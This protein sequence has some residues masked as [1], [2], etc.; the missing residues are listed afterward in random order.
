MADISR[1]VK[2]RTRSDASSRLRSDGEMTTGQLV[3]RALALKH[4]G[5]DGLARADAEHLGEL[6]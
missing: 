3:D 2:P 1:R 4:R 6:G 5:G